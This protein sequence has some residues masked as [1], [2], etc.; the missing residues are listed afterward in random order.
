MAAP[1]D[2]I[3]SDGW[4]DTLSTRSEKQSWGS[5]HLMHKV[6][7]IKRSHAASCSSQQ[8]NSQF[9]ACLVHTDIQDR[10]IRPV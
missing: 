10:A 4:I 1:G 7:E 9:L 6:E 5:A 8:I 2:T 3:Q